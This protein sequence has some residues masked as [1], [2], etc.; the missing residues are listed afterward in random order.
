MQ[1]LLDCSCV[2][3][4]LLWSSKTTVVSVLSV[5]VC[6]CVCVCTAYWSVCVYTVCVDSVWSVRARSEARWG[7]N[8]RMASRVSHKKEKKRKRKRKKNHAGSIILPASIKEKETHWPEV[9]WVSSTK[10][11]PYSSTLETLCGW[12][13]YHG[14]C[15][16]CM[17]WLNVNVNVT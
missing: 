3:V 7:R 8:V 9:P 5:C 14:G 12:K 1:G 13:R 17:T 4:Q 16:N 10:G 6:V 2:T 11:E 15:G